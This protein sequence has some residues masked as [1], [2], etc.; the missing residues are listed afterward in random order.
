MHAKDPFESKYLLLINKREKVGIKEL[1]NLK[2]FINYSQKIG[3]ADKIAGV[4]ANNILST[5]VT[6][7]F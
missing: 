5:I 6:E 3:H 4:E 2:V 7:F 1:K